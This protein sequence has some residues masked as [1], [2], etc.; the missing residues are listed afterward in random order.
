QERYRTH[1]AFRS[2]GANGAPADGARTKEPDYDVH[3]ERTSPAVEA[4]WTRI[5]TR[6]DMFRFL[7]PAV[8]LRFDPKELAA[9]SWI[10]GTVP[11]LEVTGRGLA[12][13]L[14]DLKLK[15]DSAFADLQGALRSVVPQ[16]RRLRFEWV[17]IFKLEPERVAAPGELVYRYVNREY[18]G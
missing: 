3:L 16:V 17:P 14:A 1:V 11:R 10:S 13:V 9:P 7:P 6:D 4:E 12:S 2:G 18:W 5:T 15:Q 8:L